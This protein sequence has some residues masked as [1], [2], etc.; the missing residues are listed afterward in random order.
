MTFYNLYVG[1][2]QLAI[3]WLS[4][5]PGIKKKKLK[6]LLFIMFAGFPFVNTPNVVDFNYPVKFPNN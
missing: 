5:S 4:G 6:E 3:C 1:G 2:T